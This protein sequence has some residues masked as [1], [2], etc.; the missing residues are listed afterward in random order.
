M[1]R[2][3]AITAY[4]S[5]RTLCCGFHCEA[6]IGISPY[7]TLVGDWAHLM[8]GSMCHVWSCEKI[9][10]LFIFRAICENTAHVQWIRCSQIGS[11]LTHWTCAVF[12]SIAVCISSKQLLL[13]V[14]AQHR[15]QK[16]DISRYGEGGCREKIGGERRYVN[17]VWEGH[18]TR[19]TKTNNS[20][21]L[22]SSKQLLVFVF[23]LQDSLLP[24]SNDILTGVQMLIQR[25][26]IFTFF[27]WE[28]TAVC[29]SMVSK[30]K[31]Q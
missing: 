21:F 23:D 22:L 10:T 19:Q 24:S 6:Y 17:G 29:I 11:H 14:F 4:L 28:V 30:G 25:Q 15:S 12:S 20:D 13:F 18:T 2:W 3:V 1:Q 26:T 9:Q 27:K 5:H 31:Q 7:P 16:K 8:Y